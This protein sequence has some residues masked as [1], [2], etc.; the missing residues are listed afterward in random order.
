MISRHLAMKIQ[1]ANLKESKELAQLI[2]QEISKTTNSVN[3]GVKQAGFQVLWGA[4]MP[5]VL[6]EVGFITNNNEA[7]NLMSSKYQDKIANGIANAV[8]LYKKKNDKYILQ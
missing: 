7:K 4:T 1:K 6:I 5:N 2:Q 8:M 3:R